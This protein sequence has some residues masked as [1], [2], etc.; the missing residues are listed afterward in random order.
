MGKWIWAAG[1]I[2]VPL[3]FWVLY[4]RSV[5]LANEDQRQ[6]QDMRAAAT[7]LGATLGVTSALAALILRLSGL[8][9]PNCLLELPA[10]NEWGYGLWAL[11]LLLVIGLLAWVWGGPGARQ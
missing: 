6:L 10:V 1:T 5:P 11:E 9:D 3:F 2:L 8:D 7:T 4:R